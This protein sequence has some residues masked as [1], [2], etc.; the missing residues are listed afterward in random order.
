MSSFSPVSHRRAEKLARGKLG[1]ELMKPL[2]VWPL[3]LAATLAFAG[4]TSSAD[5]PSPANSTSPVGLES[6]PESGRATQPSL[7]KG[8]DPVNLDPAN[9]SADITNP[10]WPMKPGTR[11][12]YR[13][14]EAD[15]V[16][17]DIVIVATTTT[18]KLTN[19]ITARVVRDTAREKG[20]IVEDTVD[21]YAQDS[22]GNVWYMGE[23]TAEFEN[24][25]VVSRAGSWEAGKD[26]AM[27]GIMLPAQPQDG[28]KYRQEYKKGEAEDNGEV[29]ATDH[30]VEV[31]AGRY[32]QALV[33]MDTSTI[34]PDVVEYK[35][36]APGVGPVLALD[37]SGGTAREGL[38]KVAKAAPKDGTGPIGKPNP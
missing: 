13:S 19:G 37:V 7:P 31:K 9:F 33:T 15:G 35:F 21:W 2:R 22:D 36:Y 6:L 26:G 14:V 28:Q 5:A 18:K 10:Y 27:P 29:L 23:Q 20:Q 25:K 1:E 30:L 16:A 17:Q 8:P 24:G 3:V 34:E 11:W 32:K 4:C 38:V 12:I